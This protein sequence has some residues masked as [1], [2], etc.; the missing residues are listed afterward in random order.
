MINLENTRLPSLQTRELA[1]M[2]VNMSRQSKN[3]NEEFVETRG[4][5]SKKGML[6][7]THLKPVVIRGTKGLNFERS[8][9]VRLPPINVNFQVRD[10]MSKN[11]K[12]CNA[13]DSHSFEDTLPRTDA[14]LTSTK[15]NKLSFGNTSSAS[16]QLKRTEQSTGSEKGHIVHSSQNRVAQKSKNSSQDT[17]AKMDAVDR[18][19]PMKEY[20][21][22][23]PI[24]KKMHLIEQ[25]GVR[26]TKQNTLGNNAP[27]KAVHREE[28][29]LDLEEA[30]ENLASEF[31]TTET[32]ELTENVDQEVEEDKQQANAVTLLPFKE[33]LT[34]S[35]DSKEAE[36][37]PIDNT[38]QSKKKR[39]EEYPYES[40]IRRQDSKRQ[41]IY[42]TDTH[43][44]DE[45][46][47][48]NIS[49]AIKHGR[50][51]AICEEMDAIYRDLAVIV[52]HNLLIQHLEE[53]CIF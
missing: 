12:I 40:T 50:R 32:V 48:N 30:L 19:I 23:P 4:H 28:D 47:R 36:F 33:K 49:E 8:P 46:E 51:F 20:N 16:Q 7:D 6:R 37:T 21:V 18:V 38:L 3:N 31:K 34:K 26:E 15:Q 27:K 53:I 10:L 14:M 42:Y 24:G 44:D 2:P 41:R 9:K 45:R 43:I 25:E 39:R 35:K 17:Y 29:Q 52:K 13:V 11:E 22:L 1:T 5:E